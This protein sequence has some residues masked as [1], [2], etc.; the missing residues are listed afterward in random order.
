MAEKQ[1]HAVEPS[2]QEESATKQRA[3]MQT[4][5]NCSTTWFTETDSENT[6]CALNITDLR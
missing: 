6:K 2:K 1:I 4:I 5:E 3:D